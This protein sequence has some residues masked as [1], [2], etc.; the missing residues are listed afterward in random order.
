MNKTVAQTQSLPQYRLTVRVTSGITK[1]VYV[2]ACS[3]KDAIRQY[4]SKYDCRII[5][6]EHVAYGKA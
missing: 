2:Y 5:V 6:V 3:E 1:Q 4:Q